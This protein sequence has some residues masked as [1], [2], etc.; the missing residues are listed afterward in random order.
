M[1]RHY[2][3]C[4]CVCGKDLAGTSWLCN[5]CAK[6]AGIIGLDFAQW[7]D[8]LKECKR[9]EHKQRRH[10]LREWGKTFPFSESVRGEYVVYG[11]ANTDCLD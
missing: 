1:S 7:P 6:R 4:C 2:T 10:E 3:I 8:W 11:E 5:E 9:Q